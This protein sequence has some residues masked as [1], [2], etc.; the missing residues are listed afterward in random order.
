MGLKRYSICLFLLL[1]CITGKAQNAVKDITLLQGKLSINIP[2]D[3]KEMSDRDFSLRY[4]MSKKPILILTD[5]RQQLN[6]IVE[7]TKTLCTREQF[8]SYLDFQLDS[9]K[10]EVPD[11]IVLEK[12]IITSASGVPVGFMKLN[13]KSGE[14]L[15]FN[16]FFFTTVNDELI[17][18]TVNFLDVL[19][20]RYE[21]AIDEVL[22]SIKI[23]P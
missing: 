22:S 12:G 5:E 9:Y 15:I 18:F 6:L 8:N 19:R 16:Y 7:N 21:K 17:I 10:K 11:L 23:N 2:A 20:I 14:H 13:F 1:L 4:R 3:Y